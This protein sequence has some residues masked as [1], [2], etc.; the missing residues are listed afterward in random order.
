MCSFS[1][2]LFPRQ[3]A[4]DKLKG[5]ISEGCPD[6]QF[7]ESSKA[8][9]DEH[10]AQ[11]T[12]MVRGSITSVLTKEKRCPYT[13]LGSIKTGSSKACLEICKCLSFFYYDP[14]WSCRHI[15]APL[16]LMIFQCSN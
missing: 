13:S 11:I 15:D 8:R 3:E 2:S 1:N 9:Y 12:E 16:L 4:H 7:S 5:C 6:E 14:I 10:V